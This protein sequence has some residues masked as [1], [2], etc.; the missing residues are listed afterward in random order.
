[1]I[2]AGHVLI[3]NEDQLLAVDNSFCV[4]MRSERDG[5]TGRFVRDVTAPADRHECGVAIAQL[6]KSG[7]SFE[8]TK[9]FMRDDG[10]LLWVRNSVS[11]AVGPKGATT[12][13]ATIQPVATQDHQ[14]GAP[15]LDAAQALIAA[16]HDRASVCD[17]VLFSNPGWDTVLAAY[18]AQAEGQA[19]NV[20]RLAT[21]L[22]I[23]P[24]VTSRW[25]KALVQHGV[26]E[27]EYRD[28]QADT[29]KEF[30]L[31]ANTQKTLEDYLDRHFAATS[32]ADR[33]T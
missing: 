23:S 19:I 27:I 2:E 14:S 29:A 4:I 7:K 17:P 25:V 30:R 16:R 31:T 3:G 6:R 8:I 18:V 12:I 26:L 1:M 10:S 33:V 24:T 9:R 13:M 21:S 5:M 11:L 20:A 22:G 32:Q 15:L 28:P